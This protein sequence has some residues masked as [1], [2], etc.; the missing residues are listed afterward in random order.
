MNKMI[1]TRNDTSLNLKSFKWKTKQKAT[2]MTKINEKINGQKP[3]MNPVWEVN[4][5]YTL[6]LK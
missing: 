3:N 2:I 4:I 1:E 6:D 5:N